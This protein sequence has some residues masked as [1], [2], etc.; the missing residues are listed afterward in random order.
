MVAVEAAPPIRH[1]KLSQVR[2]TL[3]C[4][5]FEC[6]LMSVHIQYYSTIYFYCLVPWLRSSGLGSS[7][8]STRT[9]TTSDRRQRHDSAGDAKDSKRDRGTGA[10]SGV[11]IGSGRN[12]SRASREQQPPPPVD[13][14][15]LRVEH[16]ERL[17]KPL[18]AHMSHADYV[19]FMRTIK[20]KCNVQYLSP[21][22]LTLFLP[23]H[24]VHYVCL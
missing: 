6:S 10:G 5:L 8:S 7:S 18:L 2:F 11:G 24:F 15:V 14:N 22:F 23:F 12:K 21:G 4:I 17:M 19:Q 16:V 9:G 20:G 1:P 3:F 13:L